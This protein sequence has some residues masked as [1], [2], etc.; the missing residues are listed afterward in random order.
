MIPQH[1]ADNVSSQQAIRA[2][3]DSKLWDNPEKKPHT[4]AFNFATPAVVHLA[5]GL[6][7]RVGVNRIYVGLVGRDAR[8][9]E[10]PSPP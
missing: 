2:G 7:L 9:Q 10:R 8:P 3:R 5:N 1:Q 6:D 4:E